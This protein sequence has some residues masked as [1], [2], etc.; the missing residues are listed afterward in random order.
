MSICLGLS[1]L[2]LRFEMTSLITI[3]RI[4]QTIFSTSIPIKISI[5]RMIKRLRA[6]R[7]AGKLSGPIDLSINHDDYLA[8]IYSEI[9]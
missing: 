2:N 5:E 6:V 8:E 4:I 7:A 3:Q 1:E 9:N